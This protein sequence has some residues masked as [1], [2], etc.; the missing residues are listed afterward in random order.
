M[1]VATCDLN[2]GN[3]YGGRTLDVVTIEYRWSWLP[4]LSP[5]L[6]LNRVKPNGSPALNKVNALAASLSFAALMCTY[7]PSQYWRK[8]SLSS[9]QRA[10]SINVGSGSNSATL[11]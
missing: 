10:L 8:S 6:R 2:C 7:A 3:R 1:A 9:A 5:P 4:A 11:Q